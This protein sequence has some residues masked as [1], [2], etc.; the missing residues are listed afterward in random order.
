MNSKLKILD[1]DLLPTH[2]QYDIL[3]TLIYSRSCCIVQY[4]THQEIVKEPTELLILHFE[5]DEEVE[6]YSNIFSKKQFPFDILYEKE[7]IMIYDRMYHILHSRGNK[8]VDNICIYE[9]D[10]LQNLLISKYLN[11]VLKKTLQKL[12]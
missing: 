12:K 6:Y 7:A 2:L 11:E 8:Y 3:H 1:F 10:N 4:K 5:E 9:Y